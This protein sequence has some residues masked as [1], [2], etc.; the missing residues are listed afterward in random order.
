MANFG[1]VSV[2]DISKSESGNEWKMLQ[3]GF[4]MNRLADFWNRSGYTGY[5]NWTYLDVLAEE[6]TGW[7][8]G[9]VPKT[10]FSGV[11]VNADL[12]YFDSD[13]N[14]FLNDLGPDG[15]LTQNQH[16]ETR[17]GINEWFFC[18][19]GNYGDILYLGATVGMPSVNFH[20]TRTLTERD[21]KNQHRDFG[22]WRLR[23]TLELSGMGVNLKLGAVVRPTDFMRLGF[24]LHTPTRYALKERLTIEASGEGG[25]VGSSSHRERLPMF[26]YNIRTPMRLIGSLGFVIARQ[27][28]IGIEYE[29][30]NYS[31]MKLT[32]LDAS[33]FDDDNDFIV[34]NYRAGGVLRVGGEYRL[35]PVSIRVGY[36]YTM[37][38][39]NTESLAARNFSGH[40]FSAGLG[41]VAG[42][43]TIDLTYV[44]TMRKYEAVPYPEMPWNRYN[45]AGHQFV[46]TFGWRF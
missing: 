29:H 35:D 17:G 33:Y 8:W 19:G 11:A 18:F 27:A 16:T 37:S 46:L 14:M 7:G 31:K 5:V 10:T 6:A 38:P 4:G 9:N 21:Q 43:T 44:N 15:G 23:E 39:Y 32:G 12:I 41:F 25:F 20:Q 13:A 45:V 36:N 22:S 26:E 34:D 30:L 42:S 1:M 3:L 28:L 40:T 24:A 2:F